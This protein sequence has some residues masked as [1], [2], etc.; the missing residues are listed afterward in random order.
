[1]NFVPR[2]LGSK[3]Q[4]GDS[5][6]PKILLLEHWSKGDIAVTAK[7]LLQEFMNV[8]AWNYKKLKRIP[9]HIIEHK[10]EL[11]TTIPPS[12]QMHYCMN[13][14]YVMIVKQNLDKLLATGFIEPM[15]QTTWLSPIVVLLKKTCAYALISRNWMP[16]P[17]KTCTHYLSWMKFWTK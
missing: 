2:H 12:H 6:G 17:K 15:E 5:R 14:N 16:P 1:M 11:D 8:F 7:D 9:P 13:P 10:I 4:H 3:D